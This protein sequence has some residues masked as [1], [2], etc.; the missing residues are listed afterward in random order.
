LEPDTERKLLI[1]QMLL[2]ALAFGA[3]ALAVAPRTSYSG[4]V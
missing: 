2:Q 4:N 1:A 3:I